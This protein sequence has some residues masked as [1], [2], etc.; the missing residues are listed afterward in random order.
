MYTYIHYN[1]LI[2][3]KG[4]AMAKSIQFV[5]GK[6]QVAVYTFTFVNVIP[7]I[8]RTG[9]ARSAGCFDCVRSRHFQAF[10]KLRRLQIYIE[11]II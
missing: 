5:Y 1:L 6:Q 10:F 7:M 8:M 9:P 11:L 3:A 2:Y 4:A